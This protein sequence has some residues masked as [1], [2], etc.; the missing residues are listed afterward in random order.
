MD[1]KTEYA[2]AVVKSRLLAKTDAELRHKIDAGKKRSLQYSS[3]WKSVN[4]NEVV[5]KFAPNGKIDLVKGKLIFTS[6]DGRYEVVCDIGGSYL[7]IWDNTLN[8]YV[9]LNG[10]DLRNCKDT[11]GKTYGRN[12]AEREKLTHF[13][14]KKRSEM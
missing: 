12:P 10:E 8:T 4:I 13:R 2:N 9:G 5:D 1:S 6:N 11:N 3:N 7:R 14:I